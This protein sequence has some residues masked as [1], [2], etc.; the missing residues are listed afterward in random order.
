MD[1]YGIPQVIK[2]LDSMSEEVPEAS[3]LYFSRLDYCS[4]RTSELCFYQLIP[5]LELCGLRRKWRIV[6]NFLIF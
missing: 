6:E 3:P 2:V 4:I 5:R 1:P